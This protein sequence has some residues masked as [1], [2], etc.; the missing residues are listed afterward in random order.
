MKILVFFESLNFSR[1]SNYLCASSN[2]GTV[3][4][5]NVQDPE[6]NRQLKLAKLGLNSGTIFDSK[7][8]MCTFQVPCELACVC[9]FGDN[10]N[11]VVCICINGAYYK[12][13]FS[14]DGKTCT[15]DQY[16]NFLDMSL[17][18]EFWI[19][20]YVIFGLENWNSML[21]QIFYFLVTNIIGLYL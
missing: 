16:E 1:D 11:S 9:A 12:Y 8:A 20:I 3:H 4:I 6:C 7:Y 10:S 18:S 19:Q 14:S 15:R 2:K 21:L 5:F 17:G 13:I